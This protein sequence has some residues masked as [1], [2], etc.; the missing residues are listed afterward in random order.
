MKLNAK[1]TMY[2]VQG[3]DIPFIGR[4]LNCN[5]HSCI[6]FGAQEACV[7]IMQQAIDGVSM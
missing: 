2:G 3:V 6:I 7:G 5:N 4:G 1:R